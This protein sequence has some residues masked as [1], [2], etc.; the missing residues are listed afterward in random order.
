M[1]RH[2]T[3]LLFIIV[4]SISVCMKDTKDDLFDWSSRI[5]T[6]DDL[7]MLISDEDNKIIVTLWVDYVYHQWGQ[8][9]K[10]QVIKDTL[11]KMIEDCH[12]NTVY[13]EADISD[14][15]IQA[16][17]FE[18]LAKDWYIDLSTLSEGPMVMIMFKHSGEMF[19]STYHTKTDALLDSIH[20]TLAQNERDHFGVQQNEC[21]INVM[22][23][24]AS[25]YEVYDPGHPYGHFRPGLKIS[26][27][28]P[29]KHPLPK[30]ENKSKVKLRDPERALQ[31]L[32]AQHMK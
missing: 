28:S 1:P 24:E 21:D 8:N 32:I 17:T 29:P 16:Y 30:K 18:D 22:V 14:Y 4:W 26:S 3:L 12:M 31:N 23:Q 6:G 2:L 19:S 15:N 20:K 11:K 5:Q 9:K 7:N 13:T 25:E 10:N 27:A